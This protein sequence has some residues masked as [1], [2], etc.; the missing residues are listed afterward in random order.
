MKDSASMISDNRPISLLGII[1]ELSA[2]VSV[3]EQ[4]EVLP[5]VSLALKEPSF[6]GTKF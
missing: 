6:I 4:K 3:N 1:Y 2:K 5:K